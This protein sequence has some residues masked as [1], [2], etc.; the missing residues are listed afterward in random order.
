MKRIAIVAVAVILV[1]IG[2]GTYWMFKSRTNGAAR[3]IDI[4][5]LK[6]D[7]IKPLIGISAD[8]GAI[9][10]NGKTM[11]FDFPGVE[12]KEVEVRPVNSLVIIS[13]RADYTFPVTIKAEL[14]QV[15]TKSAYEKIQAGMTYPQVGEALG[16]VMIKGRMSDGFT[17]K[18]E[19]IQGRRRIYLTFAA[20]KVAE[21]SAKD[22]E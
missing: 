3:A 15:L 2:F 10:V 6:V 11:K 16:G 21:K 19:I 9:V 7:S 18:I 17:S 22:L 20:G 13:G 14:P 5:S 4:S 12:A 8:G 1:L